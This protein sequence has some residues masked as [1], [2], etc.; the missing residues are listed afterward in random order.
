MK[1]DLNFDLIDLEG[2][3]INTAGKMI[4]GL[5]MS[6]LKGDAEKLFDW[7]M[8]FNSANAVEMD[9]SDLSKFKDLITKSERISTMVKAPII[10]YLNTVK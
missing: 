6:E 5:L 8:S 2:N 7:A 3:K 9:S 4:A 1:V 10:K